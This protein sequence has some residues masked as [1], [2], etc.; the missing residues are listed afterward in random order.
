M[1]SQ[2]A[3]KTTAHHLAHIINALAA[4]GSE[5]QEVR[6]NAAERKREAKQ[7]KYLRLK[8]ERLGLKVI[9]AAEAEQ[10]A[11]FQAAA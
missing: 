2:R 10:F 11:Q 8:A 6:D 3:I 5:Y 9:T 1:R 4:S 7:R